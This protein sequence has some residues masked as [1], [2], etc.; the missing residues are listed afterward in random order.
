MNIYFVST[1]QEPM[2]GLFV[3]APNRNQAKI[4]GTCEMDD[5]YINIRTRLCKK[6]VKAH[7]DTTFSQWQIIYAED[8]ET[9]A[10]YGLRYATEEEIEAAGY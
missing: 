2:F 7:F 4:A 1:A 8:Y 10:E 3:I 5:E 9:L 6:G